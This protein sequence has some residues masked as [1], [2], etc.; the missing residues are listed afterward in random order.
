MNTP[1]CWQDGDGVLLEC[2][3]AAQQTLIAILN[4]V[5]RGQYDVR[6]VS[7][8]SKDAAVKIVED[9]RKKIRR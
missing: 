2:L 3:E 6:E 5:K 7:L 8:I 9:Y 4:D 1:G